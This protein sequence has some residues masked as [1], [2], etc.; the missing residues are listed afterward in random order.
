MPI[1]YSAAN[2]YVVVSPQLY[3]SQQDHSYI[4]GSAIFTSLAAVAL[5]LYGG[6]RLPLRRRNVK[7]QKLIDEVATANS[8]EGDRSLEAMY[9]Q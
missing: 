9:I 3:L 4:Q 6:C 2:I 1:A 5:S 7:K 8:L